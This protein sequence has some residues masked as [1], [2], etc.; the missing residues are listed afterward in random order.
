MISNNDIIVSETAYGE[1]QSNRK[2]WKNHRNKLDDLYPS[3][4]Y[5]LELSGILS[6]SKSYGEEKIVV[7]PKQEESVNG[8]LSGKI[9]HFLEDNS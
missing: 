3:E 1:D 5:F 6:G 8:A 4:R 2:H 7:V 9:T